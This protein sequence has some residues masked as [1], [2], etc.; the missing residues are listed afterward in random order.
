M[1]AQGID[2]REFVAEL[3]DLEC[4]LAPLIEEAETIDAMLAPYEVPRR[5]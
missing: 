3:A 5:S 2:V 1:R 4:R